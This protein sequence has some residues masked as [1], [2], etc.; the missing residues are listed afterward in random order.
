M[1]EEIGKDAKR[2]RKAY[3]RKVKG[4]ENSNKHNLAGI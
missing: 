3:N 4:I 2:K 1:K